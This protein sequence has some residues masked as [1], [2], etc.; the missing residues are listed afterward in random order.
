MGRVSYS[1]LLLRMSFAGKS[2]WWI[3]R[4]QASG[5]RNIREV[6]FGPEKYL[7]QVSCWGEEQKSLSGLKKRRGEKRLSLGRLETN[8]PVFLVLQ[9]HLPPCELLSHYIYISHE[10]KRLSSHFWDYLSCN[11]YNSFGS[12]GSGDVHKQDI[13][14]PLPRCWVCTIMVLC[15]GLSKKREHA[16]FLVFLFVKHAIEK[17][18]KLII[19]CLK[20]YLTQ[21]RSYKVISVWEVRSIVSDVFGKTRSWWCAERNT[22]T[23]QNKCEII[24]LEKT[25]SI[26]G[27]K[28]KSK[29]DQPFLTGLWTYDLFGSSVF[30]FGGRVS[31]LFGL[32]D[33]ENRSLNWNLT[34]GN[35][36]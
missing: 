6:F 9:A 7:R 29:R 10:N 8:K 4:V 20:H 33:D 1:I 23:K 21:Y 3:S 12:F 13:F 32:K 26:N 34:G 14:Y 19:L 30:S 36:K 24:I 28:K 35:I 17:D 25:K 31:S 27:N 5:M 22:D 18:S 11:F 15:Q 16:I 2:F